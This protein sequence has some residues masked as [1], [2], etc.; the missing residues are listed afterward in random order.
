MTLTRKDY[1]TGALEYVFARPQVHFG[2]Q[3]RQCP[4]RELSA[5]ICLAAQHSI[6]VDKNSLG[7][8]FAFQRHS[9]AALIARDERDRDLE[10]KDELPIRRYEQHK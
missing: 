5:R 2:T 3:T 6:D 10:R 7:R 1:V 4:R 8:P 9:V